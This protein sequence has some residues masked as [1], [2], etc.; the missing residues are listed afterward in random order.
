MTFLHC[1]NCGKRAGTAGE[2]GPTPNGGHAWSITTRTVIEG[3][4]PAGPSDWVESVFY[5]DP[6]ALVSVL[7]CP[8]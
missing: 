8:T 6:Q 7:M 2:L 4:R 3:V 1:G 5:A